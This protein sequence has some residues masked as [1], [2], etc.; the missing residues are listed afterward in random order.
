MSRAVVGVANTSLTARQKS[1]PTT[2]ATSATTSATRAATTTG[3]QNSGA[4]SWPRPASGRAGSRVALRVRASSGRA[5]TGRVGS[6]ASSGS[7]RPSGSR[8]VVTRWSSPSVV[9]VRP[10][11]ALT[12]SAT[13][14]AGRDGS[15]WTTTRWSSSDSWTTWSSARRTRY[16]GSRMPEPWTCPRSS[17]PKACRHRGSSA[18]GGGGAV[19]CSRWVHRSG[20]LWVLERRTAGAP[21]Q[22]TRRLI[23]IRASGPRRGTASRWRWPAS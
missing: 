20:V 23:S 12:A 1:P 16:V 17:R 5:R 6:S 15:T 21:E 14:A 3:G 18:R 8:R 2:R 19:V 4:A 22:H 7:T 10:Y 11:L 9:S 13:S